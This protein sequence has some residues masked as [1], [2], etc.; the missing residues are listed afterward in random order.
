MV[1]TLKPMRGYNSPGYPSTFATTRR[2]LLRDA[3]W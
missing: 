2:D 1:V 3:A